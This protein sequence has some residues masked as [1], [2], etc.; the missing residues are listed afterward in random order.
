M[1]MLT[2]SMVMVNN[3]KQKRDS[4]EAQL[5]LKEQFCSD[6]LYNAIFNNKTFQRLFHIPFMGGLSYIDKKNKNGTSRGE[7]SVD[8]A[9]M[10]LYFAKR[11][12]LPKKAERLLVIS[13]LLHDLTH[14][15]F[16]HTMDFAMKEQEEF[17]PARE[18]FNIISQ[19]TFSRESLGEILFKFNMDKCDLLIFKPKRLRPLIFKSTHN[20]DTLDGISRAYTYFTNDLNNDN[21]FKFEILD[22]IADCDHTNCDYEELLSVWDRFWNLKNDVYSKNIYE[23]RKLIFERILGYYLYDLCENN[24]LTKNILQYSDNDIFT[25]FPDLHRKI[26]SLWDY[27]NSEFNSITHRNS[28]GKSIKLLFKMR[29]F[30]INRK[31]KALFTKMTS[32]NRRYRVLPNHSVVTIHNTFKS[33]IADILSYPLLR[34]RF[35]KLALNADH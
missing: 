9:L 2:S 10:A 5:Y 4:Y 16:S 7:L 21:S 32:L 25:M 35:E 13:S 17:S 19:N 8:V 24:K 12:K 22:A 23:V 20:I 27:I 3:K 28:E 11:N 29:R 31:V 34:K 30:V 18:A 1:N 15:P 6:S 33:D 26:E 14:L